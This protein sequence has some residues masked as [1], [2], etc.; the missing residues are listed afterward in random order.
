MFVGD[1][2]SGAIFAYPMGHGA[3][4]TAAPPLEVD[5]INARA[6]EILGVASNQIAIN[7]MAVHPVT[8]DVYLSISRGFGEGSLPAIVRV[9]P[10]GKLT[11][12]DLTLIQATSYKITDAPDETQH[13]RSRAKDWP[14]PSAVKYN[15]KA[16]IPM[17]TMT[18]VDMKF[19]NGEVFV[20]GICNEEF[21]STLRQN[22]VPV[23]RHEQ[24][25]QRCECT[26]SRTP[27][28]RRALRFGPCSLLQ[29]KGRTR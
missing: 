17:R 18:I 23:H 20:S 24:A 10:D 28:T 21:A 8:Q 12:V 19:H 6:A 3:A 5:N 16:Q 27:A 9:S 22:S 11:A 4:P 15:A 2:I 1:N 14:V 29:W 7:G 25:K 13:F 26:M